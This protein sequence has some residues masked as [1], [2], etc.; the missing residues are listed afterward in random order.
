MV[1]ENSSIDDNLDRIMLYC[2]KLDLMKHNLELPL[3]KVNDEARE[4]V[5]K[6][7]TW[8]TVSLHELNKDLGHD[9]YVWLKDYRKNN[10]L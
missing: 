6:T 10:N 5:I 8:Y 2:Q 7:Y 1:L 4:T 3:I 9:Y